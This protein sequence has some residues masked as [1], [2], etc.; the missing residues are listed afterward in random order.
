MSENAVPT[1]ASKLKI[2][3]GRSSS[4]GYSGAVELART[5]DGY[6]S[7]G[8]G[9]DERHSIE[10]PIAPISKDVFRRLTELWGFISNWASKSIFVDN[11]P[12]S[13][14]WEFGRLLVEIYQCH[15]TC[16][17]SSWQADYCSGKA[18]PAA[19]RQFFGCRFEKSVKFQD[20]GYF[21]KDEKYWYQVGHFSEDTTK[22]KIDKDAIISSLKGYN[23]RRPCALCPVFSWERIEAGVRELPN[24]IDL[25]T[26]EKFVVK[27]SNLDPKKP[28]GIDRKDGRGGGLTIGFNFGR[29][30]TAVVPHKR[31]VPSVKY[32]DVA[33]QDR[34]ITEIENVI[35]LP[36]K[37]PE[38]FTALGV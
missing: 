12:I 16:L 36:L 33:G 30:R 32:S 5:F 2:A 34:A 26:D 27:Y 14:P 37:H 7:S 10:I 11:A 24:E 22:F 13:Q 29:D 6:K 19:D 3:F 28:V 18:G 8:S 23:T 1:T 20:N 17:R 4:V 15:E 25:S 9:R 21:R 31:D 35:G 38:Y